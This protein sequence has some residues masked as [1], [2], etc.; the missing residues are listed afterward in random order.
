MPKISING[1]KL[2]G[3][4]VA[5]WVAVSELKAP[6]LAALYRLLTVNCVNIAFMT[7]GDA[8]ADEPAL[9]CIDRS[10]AAKVTALFDNDPQFRDQIRAGSDVGLLTL[11]PHRSSFK[12]L[13]SALQLL[14][15]HEICVYGMASSI[16]ALSFVVAF[17]QLERAGTILS[18][19]LRLPHSASP[20]RDTV[21]TRQKQRQ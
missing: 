18:Q 2:N 20:I 6:T 3:P 21:K 10:E 14:G 12:L 16:S 19:G 7:A 9:C 8:M 11:Y 15:E 5:F 13:G 4:L 1:L 17:E